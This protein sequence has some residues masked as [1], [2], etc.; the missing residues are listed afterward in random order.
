VTADQREFVADLVGLKE[1]R[2]PEQIRDLLLDAEQRYRA[3]HPAHLR[4]ALNVNA[5]L[6][7][8]RARLRPSREPRQPFRPAN[9]ML[10][11]IPASTRKS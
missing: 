9:H 10:D 8:A 3:R 4:A 5:R 11:D 1:V 6:R 7:H 2:T